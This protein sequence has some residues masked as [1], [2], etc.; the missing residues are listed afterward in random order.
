MPDLLWI[1]FQGKPD[2]RDPI[3]VLLEF[4]FSDPESGPIL[5]SELPNSVAEYVSHY[6]V[7]KS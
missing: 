2:F 4:N 1:F 5:D 3:K 7:E 6:N